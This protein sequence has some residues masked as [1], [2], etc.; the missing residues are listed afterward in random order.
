MY[1][2]EFVQ[3]MRS[4]DDPGKGMD[5]FMLDFL[6]HSF[7][8]GHSFLISPTTAKRYF[9]GKV[10]KTGDSSRVVADEIGAFARKHIKCFDIN[11]LS[12]Y[13]KDITKYHTD[14]EQIVEMFKDDISDLTEDNYPEKLAQLCKTL[15]EKAAGNEVPSTDLTE[16]KKN[17]EQHETNDSEQNTD[18][19]SNIPC[20][21][22]TKI[23]ESIIAVLTHL[24][25]LE[26]QGLEIADWV[27]LH[28]EY[29]LDTRCEF[30]AEFKREHQEF[31]KQNAKLHVFFDKYDCCLFEDAY[32]Y[33]DGIALDS[34]W[35]CLLMSR[36]ARIFDKQLHASDYIEILKNISNELDKVIES[37]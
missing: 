16:D 2:A 31:Q 9:K 3:R 8:E 27:L 17:E 11:R 6:G 33:R 18:C 35:R 25:T 21:A 37:S 20:A 32:P 4:I 12:V 23:N 29:M 26:H 28:S 19:L 1:Y 13:I 22:A 14:K 10:E 24:K 15:M 7:A 5:S 34:F 36:A 30:W